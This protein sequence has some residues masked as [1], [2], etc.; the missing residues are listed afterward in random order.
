MPDDVEPPAPPP[1]APPPGVEAG[2]PEPVITETMAEVYLKQGLVAEARDVYRKLVERRPGDAALRERLASL[3]R[4]GVSPSRGTPAAAPSVRPR[5]AAA[6][7]GGNSAR[8]LFGQ[9][10]S[11]RPGSKAPLSSSSSGSAMDA[12]F[13][14]EPVQATG[15]PTRPTSDELSLA[16]VFGEE[17]ASPPATNSAAPPP[18]APA[19]AGGFSFDEF[20][21][22]K[23]P[24]EAPAPPAGEAPATDAD[25]T[26]PDDFVAW[27]KGLKS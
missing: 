2:E 19:D 21:G 7:T 3:E 27:L 25:G 16:S 24:A 18:A 20:F 26:S 23:P 10:L 11:S 15:A 12:A 14:D 8:S 1:P 6:E 4:Q 17:P 5:F 9:V 13:A 22:G